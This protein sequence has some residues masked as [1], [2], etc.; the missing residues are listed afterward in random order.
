MLLLTSVNIALVQRPRWNYRYGVG[1]TAM[2]RE[3]AHLEISALNILPKILG[4]QNVFCIVLRKGDFITATVKGFNSEQRL[5]KVLH[6]SSV[7]TQN[8]DKARP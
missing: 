7:L 3:Q 8:G 5:A 6:H 2:V 4:L 1:S